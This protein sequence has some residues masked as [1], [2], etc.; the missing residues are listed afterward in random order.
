MSVLGDDPAQGVTDSD[1]PA[2][3]L[4]SRSDEF[5]H[6]TRS[7]VDTW[8]ASLT[9]SSLVP[10]GTADGVPPAGAFDVVASAADSL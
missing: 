5:L 9:Q 10:A 8:P 4:V 6:Q 2:E 1:R 7:F 3:P